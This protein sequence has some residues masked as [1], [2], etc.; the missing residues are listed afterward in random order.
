MSPSASAQQHNRKGGLLDFIALCLG[1]PS[2]ESAGDDGLLV[3][4]GVSFGYRSGYRSA[5]CKF[6][7]F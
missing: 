4:F 5:S 2:M 6:S 1:Y 7:D 3:L